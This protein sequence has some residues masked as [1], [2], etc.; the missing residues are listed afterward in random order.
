MITEKHRTL[1]E[2]YARYLTSLGYIEVKSGS[3]KYVVYW[4]KKGDQDMYYHLGIKGGLRWSKTG[5]VVDSFS[6]EHL[7][8]QMKIWE[9][10]Q[11]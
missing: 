8:R 4:R 1:R 11:I 3:L 10:G 5:K 6:S 7:F 9:R 2:R